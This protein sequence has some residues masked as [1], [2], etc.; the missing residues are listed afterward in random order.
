LIDIP[1]VT[2]LVVSTAKY[3]LELVNRLKVKM[4]DVVAFFLIIFCRHE[5]YKNK[6]NT[7]C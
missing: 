7:Q 1:F 3:I 6:K 2:N 5:I 4:T